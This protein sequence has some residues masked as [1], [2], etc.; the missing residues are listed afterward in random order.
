MLIIILVVLFLDS[1]ILTVMRKNIN[2]LLFFGLCTSLILML[3]GI[4]LYTAKIG[5]LSHAQYIFLFLSVRIQTWMQYIV[6][7]LDKLGYMIAVGRYL[8]PYFLLMISIKYSTVPFISRNRKWMYLFFL[9]PAA[10]LTL[11]YP[12]IF[13]VVVCNRFTLQTWLM[14]STL[15]WIL[16][17]LAAGMLLMIREYF[18]TPVAYF[19]R[20]F[21]NILFLHISLAFLYGINCLQDP[22]QV[23]QLY[24]S[25]YLWVSGISYSN[26]AMPLFGWVLLT[27]ITIF[28]SFVGLWNLIRYTQ[29]EY[30]MNQEDVVLQ[31]KFE[32]TNAGIS[33]FVHSIKNQILS[34]GVVH[35]RIQKILDSDPPDLPALREN[36]DLL[37]QLNENMLTHINRLNA[38]TK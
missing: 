22:I 37:R 7:T 20:Q 19:R 34:C 4:I 14:S 10:S 26:P 3:A 29:I 32:I 6:I 21:R 27:V 36:V 12:Q 38:N 35:K 5:G 28:S 1:I 30:Q 25:E 23:Y 8:F 2:S 33:I 13:Y 31:R 18:A 15:V 11:Y 16:L 24:G 17:Y 9:P